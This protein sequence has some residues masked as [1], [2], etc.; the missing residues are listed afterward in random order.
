MYINS[1]N[2][3]SFQGRQDVIDALYRAAQSS[4]AIARMEQCIYTVDRNV[5]NNHKALRDEY[6]KKA[7]R[8]DE[9]LNTITNLSDLERKKLH[10]VLKGLKTVRSGIIHPITNFKEAL[11]V[12]YTK[13]LIE[14]SKE[15]QN[16]KESISNI[17]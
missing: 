16:L 2:N 6:I 11:I 4:K 13:V 12:A 8:D 5:L 3:Q 1:T 15:I 14:K 9:F 17:A 7:C 10:S